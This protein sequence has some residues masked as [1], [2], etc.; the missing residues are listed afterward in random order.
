MTVIWICSTKF[1]QYIK[2]SITVDIISIV[3]IITSASRYSRF[4]TDSSSAVSVWIGIIH[5]PHLL[6]LQAG[7]MADLR[8]HCFPTIIWYL[9]KMYIGCTQDYFRLTGPIRSLISVLLVLCSVRIIS[10][11]DISRSINFSAPAW[12]QRSLQFYFYRFLIDVFIPDIGISRSL[13]FYNYSPS[14]NYAGIRSQQQKSYRLRDLHYRIKHCSC[15]NN[16]TNI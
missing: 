15:S 4:I 16:H 3:I 8:F 9:Y 1:I 12:F 14:N 10:E 13:C 5:R 2:Y 6:I 7:S 11:L